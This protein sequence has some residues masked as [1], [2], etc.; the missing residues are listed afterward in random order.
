[1]FLSPVRLREKLKNSR[2]GR[3]VL[4]MTV[5]MTL[6]ATASS[7]ERADVFMNTSTSSQNPTKPQGWP[8]AFEQRL[9]AGDLD[10]VMTLY[11]PE[12]H[13]VN[14]SGETLVGHDAIRKALGGLIEAKTQFRSRVVRAVTIGD[15]AQLYTDFEGTRV[16]GSGKTVAVHNNAIEVLRRQPNGP[17]KLIMGDP[18]GRE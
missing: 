5:F 10:A 18:N 13:F 1:M 14:K 4:V 17:W 16:D 2:G 15:I 11:A 6:A 3:L 9:N 7:S 12:A 8:Q